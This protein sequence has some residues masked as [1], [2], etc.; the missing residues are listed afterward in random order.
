MHRKIQKFIQMRIVAL[1]TIIGVQLLFNTSYACSFDG[2]E[3]N[4]GVLNPTNSFQTTNVT[5]GDYFVVNVNCGDNYNFNFC[6]NGAF[7]SW[8]TQIT[9]LETDGTTELAS[10][11]DACGLRSNVS[12]QAT[13][14]GSVYVLITR[15][16]C[17]L[18]SGQSA[19]MAYNVS[20]G[21]FGNDASFDLAVVDC[22]SA[23][24]TITG[25]AGGSFAF[26]T[27]PGDAAVINSTT[28]T[29]SNGT[30]GTTYNVTYTIGCASV[31]KSVTLP[32]GDASFTLSLACGGAVATITGDTGGAFSFNPAPTDGALI[33][34]NSGKITNGIAGHTYTVKYT[35][36]GASSSQSVTIVEDDCWYLNGNA[37]TIK[38]DGEECF[39]LTAPQNTQLGC[40]WSGSRIDFSTDFNLSLDYY[41]GSNIN[42][43]DGNT[44]T[45][46]PSASTA[47]GM[48]G[49]QMGAGGLTNALSVEFDT[50]DN[51]FPM[52]VYDMLCDHVAIEIDGDHQNGPPAAGPICAK[53][54][55]GNIDDGGTYEVEIDWDA[56]S[57]KLEV[58]FD[59]VLRLTYVNDIVNN[60]FGGEN[61][62]YWGA[63][64]ATGALNNR[65]YF[66]P[67]SIVILP[68]GLSSFSSECN[69][70]EEVFNWVTNSEQNANYFTLE[71]TY[72]GYVFYP[73]AVVSAV[74]NSSTT[75][76]YQARVSTS[77]ENTRYY[78]LKITD[79][80]GSYENSEII[81][82]QQCRNTSKMV[83]S[84]QQ[85]AAQLTINVNTPCEAV[86]INMMG[87]KVSGNISIKETGS[88]NLF[89]LSS[90]M[91]QLMLVGADGTNE[92]HH[93]MVQ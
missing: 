62:V 16:N 85:N 56:S 93:V 21:T 23:N 18:T 2:N 77:D 46:Q 45:F 80:D 43:A 59:G 30:P 65:Q 81:A 10:N 61:K 51:D 26:N 87:Q 12:W 8:D 73:E 76:T 67:S 84:I 42:G 17:N 60:V 69:G 31:N 68:V 70:D 41:F 20:T 37:S 75:Q 24:A 6:N 49:G 66:C 48:A 82:S 44:F 38:V 28:G 88:L 78:R 14:T 36:C 39:Q 79:T 83:Q 5:V 89:D 22:F 91:Y 13:F 54:S 27:T 11:D 15:Y 40:A 19:T 71:Y 74:G 29:I 64:S 32:G 4:A 86:L 52:H 33:D 55:S 92:V 72:D 47:C 90:G 3:T 9:V 34:E 58:Y 1:L 7:A 35:I 53:P 63:T 57:M 50:Y 25:D